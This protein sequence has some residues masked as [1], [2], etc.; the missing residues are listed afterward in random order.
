[1]ASSAPASSSAATGVDGSVGGGI[2]RFL[3]VPSAF[4]AANWAAM[5][6]ILTVIGVV[7][8]LAGATRVTT[9]VGEL[10][11]R[12]FTGVL[13]HARATWVRDLPASVALWAALALVVG[14]VL[15]LTR[16]ADGPTQ[17][18]LVGVTAPAVWAATAWLSAY[19]VTAGAA[20]A[21]AS[22]GQVARRASYLLL[23]RPLR[24]L[25]VPAAIVAVSPLWLLA[26]LTIAI[27]FSL[28][29]FLV[30]KVWGRVPSPP[31]E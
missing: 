1:M 8:A 18:F 3:T 4:F 2:V 17:V 9:R 22:L 12:A 19:V 15:V 13:R 16:V 20:E 31:E 24:A 26:P 28:P 21:D 5:L 14:D 27:G 11:D 6:L 30:A 10:G 7:P 29:P 23:S 25:V